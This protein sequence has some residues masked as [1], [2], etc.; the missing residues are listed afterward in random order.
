M[1]N[2]GYNL[3]IVAKVIERLEKG[4]REYAEE[5]DIH[6]GREWIQETIEEVLDALVYLSAKLLMIQE[7]T[8]NT[9]DRMFQRIGKMEWVIKRLITR[10]QQKINI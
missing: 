5:V 8:R 1:L 4:K 2:K 7:K 9:T 10:A 6:D 3:E